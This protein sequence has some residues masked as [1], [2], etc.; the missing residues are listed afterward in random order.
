MVGGL[1]F[2][3]YIIFILI[4]FFY[5]IPALTYYWGCTG[6]P[7]I[8]YYPGR[9]RLKPDT[10]LIKSPDIQPDIRVLTDILPDIQIRF[11]L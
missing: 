6:Y 5:Y 11:F 2:I 10:C 3:S 1:L 7:A 4:V 9:Y 8:K